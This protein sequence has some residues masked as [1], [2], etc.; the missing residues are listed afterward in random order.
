MGALLF[1]FVFF[2]TVVHETHYKALPLKSSAVSHGRE[3]KQN[4]IDGEEIKEGLGGCHWLV[5]P[6][7][8]N[9]DSRSFPE[10]DQRASLAVSG[11]SLIA[12]MT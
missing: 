8:L 1:C 4:S 7:F 6:E 5:V 3:N 9:K 10:G 11:V 2:I 12:L